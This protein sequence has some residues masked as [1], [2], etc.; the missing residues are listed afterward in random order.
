MS[1]DDAKAAVLARIRR[2]LGRNGRLDGSVGSALEHRLAVHAVG[3]LPAVDG[4][5][6]AR[7]QARHEAVHGTLDRIGGDAATVA[8]VLAYLDRLGHARELVC[9]PAPRLKGLPWPDDVSVEHRGAERDDVVALTEAYAGVAETG[10]LVLVSA[11]QT[12][13]S[14]NFLPDDCLVMLALSRLVARSED[15]W[16]LVRSELDDLPRA[17]NFVTGPSKTADVE[18]TIVYG[19]HG[20]RRLHVLLRDDL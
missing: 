17:V 14:L 15:V 2:S 9:A 18:Q 4:D 3:P 16:E 10:T 1:A 7:F 8:A 19:A 6:V 11:T 20:P 13:T 5:P 12:P